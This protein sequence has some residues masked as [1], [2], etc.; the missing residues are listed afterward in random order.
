MAAP[1][2]S[3]T[4]ASASSPHLAT[5]TA[6]RELHTSASGRSCVHVEIDISGAKG[7]SYIT[8]DHV[9]VLPRNSEVVIAEAAELLGLP[10][11]TVFKLTAKDGVRW[12]PRAAQARPGLAHAHLAPCHAP[13]RVVCRKMLSVPSMAGTAGCRGGGGR[14][15]A[16]GGLRTG[17]IRESP[18][19]QGAQFYNARFGPRRELPSGYDIPPPPPQ[20][21]GRAVLQPHRPAGR[22][23]L[24]RRPAVVP[25]QR[26]PRGAGRLRHRRR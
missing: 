24:L 14:G 3:G 9:G 18:R 23:G 25:P 7:L 16:A 11:D 12:G 20:R 1:F 21:P 2:R 15:R 10:L 19:P 6:V 26:E 13:A 4:G 8:G 5:V 22:P 17:L